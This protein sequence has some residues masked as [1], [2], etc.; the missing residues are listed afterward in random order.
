M[1]FSKQN[2]FLEKKLIPDYYSKI[3]A[4]PHF[5]VPQQVLYNKTPF[6]CPH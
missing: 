3:P 4:R 6:L 5:L 1:F 2:N